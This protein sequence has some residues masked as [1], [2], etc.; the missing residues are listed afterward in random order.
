MDPLVTRPR[1][2][3]LTFH[4]YGTWLPGDERGSVDRADRAYGSSPRGHSPGLVAHVAARMRGAPVELDEAER[5]VVGATFEEVCEHRAW[6]LLAAHVRA[7]HAHVVV[8][9]ELAP[10]RVMGTLKAY[11]SRR[12]A[13][14]G[15]RVRGTSLWARHGSTRHL[16][17]MAAV[18][19]A[20]FY[21]VPGQGEARAGVGVGANPRWGE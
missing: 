17:T 18:E 21:T 6:E 19:A 13:E 11:A 10:E 4:T 5:E 7:T 8:R 12:V 2:Y 1:A 20:C 3:F 9:A 16:W 15:L 14:A